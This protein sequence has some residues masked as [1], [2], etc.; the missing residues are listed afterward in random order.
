MN[1]IIEVGNPMFVVM[2]W[3]GVELGKYN[4]GYNL[5]AP[6]LILEN[7]QTKK[8]LALR[9]AKINDGIANYSGKNF[10]NDTPKWMLS[11]FIGIILQGKFNL[12]LQVAA[13]K[14]QS[15]IFDG[16]SLFLLD[17]PSK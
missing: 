11:A 6:T 15:A 12:K 14:N 2:L 10:E 4:G 1:R 7:V 3:G 5:A 13:L 9:M 17:V 16:V 8:H